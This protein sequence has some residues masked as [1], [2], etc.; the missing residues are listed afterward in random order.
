MPFVL[1]QYLSLLLFPLVFSPS[2]F[3][4][5]NTKE[6]EKSKLKKRGHGVL[7]AVN[8]FCANG[9]NTKDFFRVNMS[10]LFRFGTLQTFPCFQFNLRFKKKSDN[11]QNF[12]LE[13][14]G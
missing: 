8:Y 9:E 10:A 6:F 12:K 3:Y 7:N 2:E 14:V 11:S 4:W 1:L 5:E 13:F